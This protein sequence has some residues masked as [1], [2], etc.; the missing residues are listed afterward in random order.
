MLGIASRIR[1]R[2]QRIG[3]NDLD[4]ALGGGCRVVN[5]SL[6]VVETVRT[7]EM[8]VNLRSPKCQEGAGVN[9]MVVSRWW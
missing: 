1:Y 6:S 4:F 5:P 8:R 2:T 7:I 9:G 3:T